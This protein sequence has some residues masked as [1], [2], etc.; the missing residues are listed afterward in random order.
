MLA[1]VEHVRF[2]LLAG[3]P[4]VQSTI[5]GLYDQHDNAQHETYLFPNIQFSTTL[6]LNFIG[7]SAQQYFVIIHFNLIDFAFCYY[8]MVCECDKYYQSLKSNIQ[9]TISF[10]FNTDISSYKA[11]TACNTY[12]SNKSMT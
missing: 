10:S 4:N 7:Y 2:V 11:I 12:L 6:R 5:F 9:H 8:F 3:M 1:L